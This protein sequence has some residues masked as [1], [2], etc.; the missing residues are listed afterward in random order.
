MAKTLFITLPLRQEELG[1][2]YL[3]AALRADGHDTFLIQMDRDDI[4]REF[5]KF[6]PDIVAW[7]VLTGSHHR[8]LNLNLELKKQFDFI[9]VF[10][11]PHVTFFPDN[12]NEAGVDM[13]VRGPGE[14][15]LVQIARGKEINPLQLQP[16]PENPDSFPLP[17]RDLLYRYPYL[18][19]NPMKNIITMR[20]CPFSCTY[21]YNQKYKEFYSNQ[22]QQL[23][24][25]RSVGNVIEEIIRI[26]S[27][28]N[29]EMILF[30]DD[31]FTVHPE[32]VHEF[33]GEYKKEIG[34]PFVINIRIDTLDE[35]KVQLLADAGLV[36]VN[37]ALE[38]ADPVVRRD[39]LNRG[40]FTNEKL[41]ESLDWLH[42]YNVRTR[43]LNMIGLPLRDSLA[44]AI[45]TLDFNRTV[46][47][48]ESW[49]CIFQPYPNT[50]LGE[51]TEKHGFIEQ[52]G[53]AKCCA[54]D[55][56]SKSLLKIDGAANIERLQKWWF[57]ITKYG[58]SKILTDA[59]METPLS[60][61]DSTYLMDARFRFSR[62]LFYRFKSDSPKIQS[63]G[64]NDSPQISQLSK[65]LLSQFF[66]GFSL[67][68]EI[69]ETIVN[70]PGADAFILNLYNSIS[71]K[72]ER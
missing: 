12:I 6:R 16:Y 32:W 13:Q 37:C 71:V 23:L 43:L 51:Y 5:K 17:H 47:P 34:L 55:V 62:K 38:S 28:Y 46:S 14:E 45:N 50:A 8:S 36:A 57:F 64:L 20:G 29:L 63:S 49:A 1:I 26:Q 60:D 56:F 24:K 11:G 3:S 21:C 58:L 54:E 27:E 18:H 15:A 69:I 72:K 70:M 2:M 59:L 22:R 19:D 40:S 4:V 42:K 10:G 41:R 53:F 35:D 9:S 39:L 44:D 68:S 7:P 66:A 25:R 33:C 31:H 52:G 65:R 61:E 48:S 67:D 30:L